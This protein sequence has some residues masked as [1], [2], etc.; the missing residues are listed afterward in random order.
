MLQIGNFSQFLAILV[1][2]HHLFPCLLTLAN[3]ADEEEEAIRTRMRAIRRLV[4]D[5]YIAKARHLQLEFC[6]K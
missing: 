1:C 3:D 5:E 4:K 6:K 2:I